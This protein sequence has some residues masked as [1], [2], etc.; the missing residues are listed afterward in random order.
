[1]T[2]A[3]CASARRVRR[4]A[5][6]ARDAAPCTG[7]ADAPDWG[8]RVG[9]ARAGAGPGEV[10]AGEDELLEP[11][12]VAD[13][14]R[15]ALEEVERD[16]EEGEVA[17]P[18]EPA[19]KGPQLVVRHDDRVHL[20]ARAARA[21]CSDLGRGRGRGA[22]EGVGHG[23]ACRIEAEDVA[24]N[25]GEAA[26]LEVHFAGLLHLLDP[27]QEARHRGRAHPGNLERRALE[28]VP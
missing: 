1:M 3:A 10:V 27:A 9:G 24:G 2:T 6:C 28:R 16:V 15:E 21:P 11:D 19:R 13:L 25:V 7:R 22:R 20:A 4:H 12:A 8:G 26:V 18:A 5:G 17:E 23:E 14:G